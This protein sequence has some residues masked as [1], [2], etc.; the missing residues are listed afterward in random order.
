MT[1][2]IEIV[3]ACEV[4]GIAHVHCIGQC[5]LR[6]LGLILASLQILV[7]DIVGIVGSN[8]SLDGESHLVTK[9]GCADVAKVAT[10][11]AHHQIVSLALSLHSCVSIEVIEC[12]RQETGHVDTIG[13][14]Q[15]HVLVQ[16]CVH[17][18]I[19]H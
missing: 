4:R 3:D 13:R 14:C 10:W 12:L 7:E 6:G 2:A 9:E 16:F 11:N 18:S 19:L 15:F 5:L 8:E 17:E 1:L